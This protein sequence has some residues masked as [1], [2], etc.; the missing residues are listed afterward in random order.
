METALTGSGLDVLL[1]QHAASDVTGVDDAFTLCHRYGGGATSQVAG[2]PE[3]IDCDVAAS[4]VNNT[5]YVAL[6]RRGTD[7]T[8]QFCELE[9]LAVSG[10]HGLCPSKCNEKKKEFR[11]AHNRNS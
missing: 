6:V 7:V 11:C 9:V 2:E 5:R 10:E 3:K 8:L 4:H 1:G